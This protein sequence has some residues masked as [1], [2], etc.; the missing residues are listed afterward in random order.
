MLRTIGTTA[1]LLAALAAP[2]AAVTA[3]EFDKPVAARKA[4]M[5]LN[6]FY[7]GQLGAMAKGKVGYD[8]GKAQRAADS[9]L[10]L[11][12]LDASAMWPAGSGNDMLGDGT[13][14]KPE[15]WG[16]NSDVG[17]K[18]KDLETAVEALVKVAGS[19]LDG[20]G[21]AVKAVGKTCGGCHKPYRAEKKKQ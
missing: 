14:A 6:S 17:A 21:G 20:L 1:L 4:V 5:K 7:L 11:A 16:A 19:G 2:T 12:K 3:G 18:S 10:A 15:I 9:L 13:R 8:A